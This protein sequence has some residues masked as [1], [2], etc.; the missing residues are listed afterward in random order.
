MKKI[1][2]LILSFT[3]LVAVLIFS[4]ATTKAEEENATSTDDV[5]C[6]LEYMPVC[7]VD[8]KTYGN[9]C[10]AGNV[11]IAYEGECK[12]EKPVKTIEVNGKILERILNPEQIK[13]FRVMKNENGTLYGIRIQNT[14]QTQ[15]SNQS[16]NASDQAKENANVNSALIKSSSTL[17]KIPNP[18]QIKNFRVMKNENGTLYGIR[19][20]AINKDQVKTQEQAR[21]QNRVVNADIKT[22]VSTAINTKD[23]ALKTRLTNMNSEVSALIDARN[24]CQNQALE[25]ETNQAE[26]LKACSAT[27]EVKY[28]ELNSATRENHKNIWANYQNQMKACL[29]AQELQAGETLLIE[30]G[31][32]N[33]L[34]AAISL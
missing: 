20:Q 4:I 24:A 23:D 27:F 21:T 3:L 14:N 17:E 16:A 2:L 8:G 10:T 7:G 6:T 5:I 15:S 33:T 12:T 31:G 32:S 30:D 28:K 26:N 18:E 19:I 29:P 25:S 13:N 9:K 1:N 11:T 34:E 22:C